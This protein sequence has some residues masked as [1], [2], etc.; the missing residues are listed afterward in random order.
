M[1]FHKINPCTSGIF[2]NENNKISKTKRLDT[3]W[4]LTVR[5]MTKK[6]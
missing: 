1:I 5:R 6:T 3:T 4:S 2:I